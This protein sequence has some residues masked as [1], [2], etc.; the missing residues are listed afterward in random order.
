LSNP[1]S[2]RV[3]S[4]RHG[5]RSIERMKTSTIRLTAIIGGLVVSAFI[6]LVVIGTAYHFGMGSLFAKLTRPSDEMQA[7]VRSFYDQHARTPT[8]VQELS[9]HAVSNSFPFDAAAYGAVTF[10]P[11]ND[12]ITVEYRKKWSSGHCYV[13]LEDI[14]EPDSFNGPTI[15]GIVAHFYK[16]R[17]RL[18][19]SMKE[20]QAHVQENQ[21]VFDMALYQ[22]VSAKKKMFG[23][24][25][26]TSSWK[27]GPR[28]SSG[29]YEC[30]LSELEDLI[31][32]QN[33]RQVSS[34]SAPSASPDEPSM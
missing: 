15:E 19:C 27:R 34:E 30:D 26:I 32:E 16:V 13:Y 8:N 14:A 12:Y 6:G 29:S 20:I 24:V 17:G 25:R 31:I 10:I 5:T 23:R 9:V 4:T 21:L 1:R 28:S 7:A 22:S 11:S 2:W 18:P 3:Y 33:I